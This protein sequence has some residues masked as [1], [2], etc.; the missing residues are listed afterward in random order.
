MGYNYN[1]VNDIDVDGARKTIR[2]TSLFNN[3]CRLLKYFISIRI[4]KYIT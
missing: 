4:V 3:E 2:I 1:T